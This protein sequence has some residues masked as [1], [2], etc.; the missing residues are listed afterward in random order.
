[1]CVNKP[2][3]VQVVNKLAPGEA[4]GQPNY[5]NYEQGRYEGNICFGSTHPRN[6]TK[7]F[8]D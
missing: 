8:A 3:D 1:M 4:S 7:D 5:G 2:W 6:S